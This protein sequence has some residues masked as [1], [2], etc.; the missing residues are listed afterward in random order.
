MRT[1]LLVLSQT[2]EARGAVVGLGL[3]EQSLGCVETI[4][5]IVVASLHRED[6]TGRTAHWLNTGDVV[7]DKVR[8][9]T[10]NE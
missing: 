3:V 8:H 5:V 6:K 4:R 1:G 10:T 9:G 2:V 7:R